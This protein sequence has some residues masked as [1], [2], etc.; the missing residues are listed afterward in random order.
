MIGRVV[1]TPAAERDLRRLPG[2]DEQRITDEMVYLAEEPY[3]YTYV[4]KLKGHQSTPIYSYWVGQY[5]VGQYRVIL[6]IEGDIMVIFVIEI[7][8]QNNVCRKY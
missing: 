1:F 5:R 7:G 2:A 3:L 8:H 4:K 6:T